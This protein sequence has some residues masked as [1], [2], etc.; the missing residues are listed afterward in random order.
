MSKKKK[1]CYNS[2]SKVLSKMD[3]HMDEIEQKIATIK[4]SLGVKRPT[5]SDEDACPDLNAG[6]IDVEEEVCQ[7]EIDADK[8]VIDAIQE[9]YVNALLERE[10]EGEA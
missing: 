3:L 1:V 8:A 9:L 10:P 2:L 7:D 4:E 6:W 5:E